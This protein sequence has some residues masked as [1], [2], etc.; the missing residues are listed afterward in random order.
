MFFFQYAGRIVP[1]EFNPV[2]PDIYNMS[3]FDNPLSAVQH[4]I[5]LHKSICAVATGF[6]EYRSV[7]VVRGKQ[8]K[9]FMQMYFDA[10]DCETVQFRVVAEMEL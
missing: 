6:S 1:D 8:I 9:P 3:E 10:E 5:E 2:D 4:Y 7:Y